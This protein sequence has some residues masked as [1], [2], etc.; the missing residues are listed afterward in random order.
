MAVDNRK[1]KLDTLMKIEQLIEAYSDHPQYVRIRAFYD[2]IVDDLVSRA[3]KG[4]SAE[5]RA[6]M[7]D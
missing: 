2:T 3:S 7:K 1:I 6:E 4:R 5:E